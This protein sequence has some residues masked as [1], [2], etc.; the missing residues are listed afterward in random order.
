MREDEKPEIE[1]LGLRE[2]SSGFW[3]I[4]LVSFLALTIR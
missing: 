4:E 3:L 1:I 2:V